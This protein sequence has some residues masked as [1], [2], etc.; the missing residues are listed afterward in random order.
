MDESLRYCNV[1]FNFFSCKNKKKL[2]LVY[3]KNNNE[4]FEM[5]LNTSTKIQL[6]LHTTKQEFP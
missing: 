4:I 3:L 6:W 5:F 1:V 2:L